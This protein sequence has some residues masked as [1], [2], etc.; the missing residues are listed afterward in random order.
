LLTHKASRTVRTANE[1]R[2]MRTNDPLGER[3]ISP[4]RRGLAAE[5]P[6]SVIVAPTDDLAAIGLRRF[7]R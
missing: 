4:A 1:S 6:F 2:K 7:Y 5:A 3:R